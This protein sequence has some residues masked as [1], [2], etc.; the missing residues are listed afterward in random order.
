MKLKGCEFYEFFVEE[1][2]AKIKRR[3]A[4]EIVKDIYQFEFE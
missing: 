3:N 1:S 4:I 2:Y